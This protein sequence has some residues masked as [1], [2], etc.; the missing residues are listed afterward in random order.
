[1]HNFL[2][3]HEAILAALT[4]K[5]AHIAVIENTP[6]L[7][8]S[9]AVPEV[10]KLTNQKHELQKQLKLLVNFLYLRMFC[11]FYCDIILCALITA[12]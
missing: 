11:R 1:M 6:S 12:L 8:T 7:M 10:E 5:D 4:E 9:Q 2:R 3:R